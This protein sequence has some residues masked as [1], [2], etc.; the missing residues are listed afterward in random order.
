MSAVSLF[1]VL[2][3]GP[4]ILTFTYG[5]V[6]LIVF[7]SF[8][9]RLPPSGKRVT[10]NG[11]VL[12]KSASGRDR[13]EH[14]LIAEL[15]LDRRLEKWEVVHHINGR[16]TDNRLKNLCV[17]DR[18]DHDR[19]HEWYDWIYRSYGNYPRRETQLR[20]LREDFKGVLLID[21]VNER[22]RSA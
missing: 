9:I 11:Y 8:L 6:L 2:G 21:F 17:M 14:R 1:H 5:A 18:R 3:L 15:I 16:R 20:K 12:R 19:Y 7:V 13:Y 4:N 22:D 10:E